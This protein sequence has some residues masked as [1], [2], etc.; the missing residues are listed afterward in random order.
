VDEYVRA[1]FLGALQALTEFLPISSSGHLLIAERLLGLEGATLTFDVG[2]HVGTLLAVLGYFR[3]DWLGFARALLIDVTRRGVRIATWSA[4]SRLLL[5][6]ALGTVPAVIAGL[7]LNDAIE[8][9]ARSVYVV[10]AT[11]TGFGLV[12]EAA[13]RRPQSRGLVTMTYAA[14]LLVGVAQAVALVPGV[15]RSGVT[16]S[17]ARALG[18]E[19]PAAARFSF[20]LSAPVVFAA[21]VLELGRALADGEAIAWGPL[22]AGAATAAVVG[23]LVIAGLLAFLRTRTLRPFVWYRIAL[24][25][26]VLAGALTGAL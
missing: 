9:Y 8:R 20:L 26:A 1:I 15:S 10:V 12:L 22:L 5:A 6:I 7:L 14:A 21:A 2:L 19:R 17:A 13:D 4:E 3:A 16:I 24:G 25:L 23:W 11:V 18:F